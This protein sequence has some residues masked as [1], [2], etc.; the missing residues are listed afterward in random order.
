[1]TVMDDNRAAIRATEI[2]ETTVEQLI[3]RGIASFRV[4]DVSNALGVSSGLIHYHFATKDQLLTAAFRFEAQRQLDELD[5]VERAGGTAAQRL[6][7]ALRLYGPTG[8]AIGWRLWIDA[9]SESL[10]NAELRAVMDQVNATWTGRVSALL[11]ANARE[12]DREP[13]DV[14]SE[15]ARLLA[16]LDGESIR[17]VLRTATEGDDA[18]GEAWIGQLVTERLDGIVLPSVAERTAQ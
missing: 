1:M 2:L 6:Q 10:R 8:R 18:V 17:V 5:L 4:K 16:W 14:A 3:A 11:L 12:S 13:G 15:A 7:S 9:W